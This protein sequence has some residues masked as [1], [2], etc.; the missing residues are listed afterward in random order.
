MAAGP[1]PRSYTGRIRIAAEPGAPTPSR[2]TGN[3]GSPEEAWAESVPKPEIENNDVL[4]H[5]STV[6]PVDPDQRFYLS[7][8]IADRR[9]GPA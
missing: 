1:P 7:P 6:G 3:P 2:P 5:A 8:G 9:G 4:L